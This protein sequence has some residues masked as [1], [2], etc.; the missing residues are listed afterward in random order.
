MIGLNLC[1]FAKA[2]YVKGQVHV[3]VS[4]ARTADDVNADLRAELQALLALDVGPHLGQ[5]KDAP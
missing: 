3:A 4:S 5:Q 2:V 1:P